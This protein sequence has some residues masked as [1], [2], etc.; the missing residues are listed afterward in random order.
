SRL[1]EEIHPYTPAGGD[2]AIEIH[3]VVPAGTAHQIPRWRKAMEGTLDVLGGHVGVYP[4]DTFTLVLPPLWAGRT[5]GMEYPTLVTGLPGD[6]LWDLSLIRD[7]HLPES[8][9]AHEVAH[10]WFYGLIATNE[11]E[12]GFLDEG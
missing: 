3:Y 6:P 4:Y 10:N 9:I 12:E 5:A 2:H 8:A 1:V 7:V 11:Q